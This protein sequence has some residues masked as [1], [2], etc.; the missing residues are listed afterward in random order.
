MQGIAAMLSILQKQ[1]GM[2]KIQSD[3]YSC[4]VELE[5]VNFGVH[6]VALVMHQHCGRTIWFIAVGR[7]L[8]VP[9]VL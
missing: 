5:F 7:R 8:L 4:M 2:Y 3:K 1:E 9:F 6:G